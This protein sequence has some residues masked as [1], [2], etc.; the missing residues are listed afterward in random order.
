MRRRGGRRCVIFAVAGS[1]LLGPGLAQPLAAQEPR[2]VFCYAPV[3]AEGVIYV[4]STFAVGP[5]AERSRYGAQFTE[6]L[7]REG[8]VPAAMDAASC[9]MRSTEEWIAR[10]R[11]E[12]PKYC[13]I[14]VERGTQSC[15]RTWAVR[16]VAWAGP[17]AS[18]VAAAVREGAPPVTP[19]GIRQVPPRT[20]PTAA[21][22]ADYM[23]ESKRLLVHYGPGGPARNG[24]AVASVSVETRLGRCGGTFVAAHRLVPETFHAGLAYWLGGKSYPVPTLPGRTPPT[25]VLFATDVQQW[26]NTPSAAR[27]RRALNP[28]RKVVRPSP[29]IDCRGDRTAIAPFTAI[30]GTDASERTIKLFLDEYTHLGFAADA[31]PYTDAPFEAWLRMQP[32]FGEVFDTRPAPPAGAHDSSR[33]RE[34]R[35]ACAV[36][37]L[38]A[39]MD[40]PKVTITDPSIT[41]SLGPGVKMLQLRHLPSR[42][43]RFLDAGTSRVPPGTYELSLHGGT[44]R[45]QTN[46]CVTYR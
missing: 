16:Q 41:A 27:T 17:G 2:L 6:H 18:G 9:P 37:H 22:G 26:S 28:V 1:V 11:A 38:N 46:A 13:P 5:V 33:A 8:A 35:T 32:G 45:A 24:Y 4:S 12:L 14:D 10:D 19:A 23:S 40:R 31:P 34:R 36:L 39:A 44:T 7:V 21:T 43:I 25:S 20:A 42:H 29:T 3:P 15:G 30:L